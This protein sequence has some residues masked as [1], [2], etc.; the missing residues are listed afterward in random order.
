MV[1]GQTQRTRS[2][3]GSTTRRR[4]R[5]ASGRRSDA[6][7]SKALTIPE[8]KTAFDTVNTQTEQLLRA[9]LPQ[10]ELVKR[11]QALWKSV[12]H[13]PVTAA[14]A[15]AYL[16]I[17]RGAKT[18]RMTR[19]QR[20]GAT[21]PLAGAPLDYTLRPGVD[22]VHGSFPAYVAQGQ[23]FYNHVNQSAIQQEC[24][25]RD[26]TPVV[27]ASIG[28]NEVAQTGGALSDVVRLGLTRPFAPAAVPGAAQDAQDYFLG[29]P[30][31]ASSDPSQS[32]LT[33]L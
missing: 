3:K 16:T 30:L 9:G 15:S 31:S 2:R 22:G 7:T 6:T 32:K 11:F 19:K 24:G 33:I 20:G 18:Y 26:I 27:P 8:L 21:A 25:V 14:A 23:T 13:R 28:S 4:S 10:A 12:F 17:K 29:R 5:T 1:S